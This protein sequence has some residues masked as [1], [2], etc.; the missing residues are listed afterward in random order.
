MV[1][2]GWGFSTRGG[3]VAVVCCLTGSAW[4]TCC[5]AASSAFASDIFF[6][7]GSFPVFFFR[8]VDQRWRSD[9]AWPLSAFFF[10]FFQWPADRAAVPAFHWAVALLRLA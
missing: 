9:H 5:E 4:R 1:V 7:F 6:S 2:P 10:R 3:G 8:P